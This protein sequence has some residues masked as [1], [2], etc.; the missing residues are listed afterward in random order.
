MPQQPRKTAKTTSRQSHSS[1]GKSP[2]KLRDLDTP[3]PSKVRGGL[4]TTSTTTPT[5]G[6]SLGGNIRITKTIVPCV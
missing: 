6:G 1:T 5:S 3:D 2:R 4:T